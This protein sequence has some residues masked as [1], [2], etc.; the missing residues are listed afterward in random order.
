LDKAPPG[1][2]LS[3]DLVHPPQLPLL[4]LLL[5]DGR[6]H[7]VNPLLATVNFRSVK[8]STP[9][10]LRNSLPFL[11]GVLGVQSLQQLDFLRVR[12]E[13]PQRSIP[14]FFCFFAASLKSI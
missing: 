5:V 7:E 1:A 13:L 3:V 2:H 10:L 4:P 6:V 12:L 11:G 14:I 8:P 9:K